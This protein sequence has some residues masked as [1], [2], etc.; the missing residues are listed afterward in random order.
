MTDPRR[1]IADIY[2]LSPMQEGLLF[3][4][5][6]EGGAAGLYMPQVALELEGAGDG[7][8]LRAAW[9]AALARH[10]VLRS[11]MHWEER[12]T[13]FQVVRHSAPLPWEVLDWRGED[14]PERLD[15]LL[16]ANRAMPFDLRRPPLIAL[17]FIRR[18]A[19]RATLVLRYH[20]M[21]LDGW[22]AGLLLGEVLGATGGAPQPTA[23]PPY[24]DY[25]GWL[26]RQDHA[27]ALAFW[28]D[29]L[30]GVRP[31]LLASGPPAAEAEDASAE[32]HCPPALATALKALRSARGLTANTLV[33]GA[34]GLVLAQHCGRPEVV[35]G[36][37]ASGRPA[38]LPGAEAMVGLFVTT[39]PLRLSPGR[40]ERAGDWLQALQRAR[41]EAEAQAFPG[42]RRIQ[43]GH[44][45]LFDCLLVFENYPV[46]APAEGPLTLRGARFDERTHYPLTVMASEGARGLTV[47]ARSRGL[48]P[49]APGPEALLRALGAM[50]GRLA[51]APEAEL[52]AL[53]PAGTPGKEAAPA[54]RPAAPSR[55]GP[56]ETETERAVAAAWAQVLRHPGPRL[57]DDFFALGG[58]SLLA[59]RV[60]NALRRDFGARLP[61]TA[62][63]ERPVLAAYAE[64]LDALRTAARAPEAAAPGL[65]RVEI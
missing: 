31:T 57:E 36:T 17:Q 33:T 38:D 55:S 10:P 43:A 45:P 26:R 39:L 5:V 54:P 58:H 19:G 13:P 22:S 32:W 28:R 46:R 11:S 59:A 12:D 9:E 29:R 23:P 42:L 25:I 52:G 21:V 6:S 7:T 50:L 51:E 1:D 20:H 63:F 35:L 65:R 49:G 53:L 62:L 34:L 2:P 47:T 27:A 18:D 3:H 14:G 60:T 64:H 8:A 44:G 56:P 4:A 48:P 16:A 40:G 61:V 41:A 15:T 30:E 37:S 24:S